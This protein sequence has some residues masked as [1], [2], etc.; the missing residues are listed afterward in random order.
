MAEFCNF[1]QAHEELA[2]EILRVAGHLGECGLT[3]GEILHMPSHCAEDPWRPKVR[4]TTEH[5]W[6]PAVDA[7][8][9]G[10]L[11]D[12]A[13]DRYQDYEHTPFIIAT[14]K[15]YQLIADVPPEKQIRNWAQ[16]AHYVSVWYD[17]DPMLRE[18]FV[19]DN[20]KAHGLAA[21]S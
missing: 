8:L 12:Q 11:Q 19:C 4:T 17:N 14:R 7:S 13:R 21:F 1:Y 16:F 20:A 18:A 15:I 3:W 2:V 6:D 5:N 9:R 10:G